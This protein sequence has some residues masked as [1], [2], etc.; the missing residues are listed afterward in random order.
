VVL[1]DYVHTESTKVASILLV[2]GVIVFCAL[3]CAVSI[4]KLAL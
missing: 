2:N 3:A 1:E 4:L